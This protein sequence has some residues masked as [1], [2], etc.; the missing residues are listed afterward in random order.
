MQGEGRREPLPGSGGEAGASPSRGR[1][2]LGDGTRLSSSA[3]C[4]DGK[5]RGVQGLVSW[6]I[7][8]SIVIFCLCRSS[9]LSSFPTFSTA[10]YCGKRHVST[11]P[12]NLFTSGIDSYTADCDARVRSQLLNQLRRCKNVCCFAEETDSRL[13]SITCS[14]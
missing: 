5:S 7:S 12:C 6:C 10:F 13:R 3:C 4:L 1:P 14:L 2:D 8:F 11:L 9:N